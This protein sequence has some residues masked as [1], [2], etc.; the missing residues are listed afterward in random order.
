MNRELSLQTHVWSDGTTPRQFVQDGRTI[1]HR[2]CALCWREFVRGIDG[3][4]DWEAAHAGVFRIERLAQSVTERWLNEDCPKRVL[5]ADDVARAMRY[6][7]G[8][9]EQNSAPLSPTIR[10]SS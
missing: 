2:H 7:D 1:F 4:S 6:A 8:F 3:V 9:A 10:A 5:R